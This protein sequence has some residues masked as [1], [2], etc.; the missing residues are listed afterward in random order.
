MCFCDDRAV[1]LVAGKGLKFGEEL[2]ELAGDRTAASRSPGTS[3][4]RF[5]VG[6]LFGLVLGFAAERLR[7]HPRVGGLGRVAATPSAISRPWAAIALSDSTPRF[8]SSRL[9]SPQ[10]ASEGAPAP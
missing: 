10:P 5:G 7:H 4:V 8:S 9:R 1:V 2:G 6:E 3:G